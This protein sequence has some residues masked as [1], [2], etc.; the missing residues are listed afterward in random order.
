MSWQLPRR[1]ICRMHDIGVTDLC[2]QAMIAGR[3]IAP[4]RIKAQSSQLQLILL[5]ETKAAQS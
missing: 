1:M 3:A 5:V 2:T 4:G